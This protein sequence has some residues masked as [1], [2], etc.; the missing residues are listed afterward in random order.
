MA[1]VEQIDD[2][3]FE[4]TGH[5][6]GHAEIK[7]YV[8]DSQWTNINAQHD[9]YVQTIGK[10][11]IEQTY[12]DLVKLN[13]K[14][15]CCPNA[16]D[17]QLLVI[18]I[19]FSDSSSFISPDK[20]DTVAADI[21]NAVFGTRQSTNWHSVA[22][23]YH[24]ES[25]GEL[26]ITGTVGGWYEPKIDDVLVASSYYQNDNDGRT[27]KLV[28]SAVDDY[29]ANNS[30]SRTKYDYDGDGYLDGVLLFYAAPDYQ[31]TG[32]SKN[33]LWAYKT[34][35]GN[36]SYKDVN[37]PG[38]NTFF[39]CSYDF[40][41]G[42]NIVKDHTG[43]NYYHGNTVYSTIDANT[44][45]HE[46]G[47]IFGL[48]D[49]YDY[50]HNMKPA[51]YFSTQDAN[52]GGHDPF[53]SMALGWADPFIPT[54][55]CTIKLNDFQS[56]GEVIL[57]TPEFNPYNSPFDEYLLL[58]LYTPTGLNYLDAG[59]KGVGPRT[60]GIRLWHVDAILYKT[61]G[62]NFTRNVFDNGVT[63]TAFNNTSRTKAQ[64]PTSGRD[65]E[66]YY[67]T[68]DDFYQNFHQLHL[69]RKIASKDF[70]C[71]NMIVA[72]DLFV[73]DDVFT[74]NTYKNQFVK[75]YFSRGDCMD[76]GQQLG[77]EFTVGEIEDH[78]T[79]QYSVTITLTKTA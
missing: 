72:D 56:S 35:I 14:Y 46:M 13:P 7:F 71:N 12:M 3:T 54:E 9:I 4:I 76:F 1:T 19:W 68:G 25:N 44:V 63:T 53:S 17:V 78:L 38:P 67:R 24:E 74:F 43:F 77:W 73:K 66:A 34:S 39:W 57:L 8:L 70:E 30:D 5:Q 64:D 49:Y 22:S 26:N 37:T 31:S 10:T 41:Y 79:G 52:G 20:K 50:C 18:P 15:S 42:S 2:R 62:T 59:L 40:L 58:E 47:H 16:G 23:F 11:D 65:C 32:D 21:Y 51:G 28:K 60:P 36:Q 61:T 33:N 6:A 75:P 48:N 29:F 69:I 45:I 55:S 27:K